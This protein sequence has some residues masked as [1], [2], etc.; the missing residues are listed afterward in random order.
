[1]LLI[2][3]LTIPNLLLHGFHAAHGRSEWLVPLMLATGIGVAVVG[4]WLARRGRATSG[5]DDPV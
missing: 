3:L 5:D 2:P 4:R 1:M